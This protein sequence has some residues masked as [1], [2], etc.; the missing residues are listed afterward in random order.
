MLCFC[1]ELRLLQSVS[2]VLSRL[3]RAQTRGSGLQSGG[4]K[5]DFSFSSFVFGGCVDGLGGV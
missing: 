2:F 1:V 5:F 4:D 3:S